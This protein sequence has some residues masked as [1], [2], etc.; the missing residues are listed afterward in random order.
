VS[1]DIQ[2]ALILEDLLFVLMVRVLLGRIGY[3]FHI[4]AG[5]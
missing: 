1:L 4:S 3:A 2:E 5:D